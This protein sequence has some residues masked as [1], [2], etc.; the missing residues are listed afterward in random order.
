MQPF[1]ASVHLDEY[2]Y[3]INKLNFEQ[4]RELAG[5][6][7]NVVSFDD[8]SRVFI[9]LILEWGLQTCEGKPKLQIS[10]W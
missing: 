9:I 10:F 2:F 1:L 6:E 3:T 7:I 5:F 4:K 8:C